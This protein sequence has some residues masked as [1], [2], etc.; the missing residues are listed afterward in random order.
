MSSR[1]LLRALPVALLLLLLLQAG[2]ASAHARYESSNPADGATVSS[3]PSQVQADFSEPVTS[4]SYLQVTDPCGEIVSGP[5]SPTADKVTVSM[6]G[7]AAG[8]YT[9]YFRVQSSIDSHTTDGTFSFTSS[10]GDPCAGQE[11][12]SGGNEGGNGNSRETRDSDGGDNG[13]SGGGAETTSS[14]PSDTVVDDP[15]ADLSEGSRGGE[16]RRADHSGHKRGGKR[17]KN[18]GRDEVSLSLDRAAEREQPKP[19]EG[20]PAGGV[21]AALIISALIGAAGGRIYASIMGP[22]A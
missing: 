19:W 20:L 3:P 10:G 8:R 5:S 16:D 14:D 12:L 11:P 7:S 22:R 17:N 4:D 13:G 18:G 1:S 21:I 9:V 6:N 15:A 2:P